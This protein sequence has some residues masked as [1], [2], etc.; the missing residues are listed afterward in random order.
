MNVGKKLFSVFSMLKISFASCYLFIF[1]CQL[2]G[3]RL[4]LL[5][6]SLFLLF[7]IHCK[8]IGFYSCES[9]YGLSISAV[10]AWI[11]QMKE[12]V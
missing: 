10:F 6:G 12:Y 3:Y 9:Y 4:S 7:V 1:T 11:S 2:Q 8:K 5:K